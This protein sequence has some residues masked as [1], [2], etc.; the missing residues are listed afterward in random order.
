MIDKM[1]EI[2]TC[3]NPALENGYCESHQA[4]TP[5]NTY[6]NE[7]GK[8]LKLLLEKIDISEIIRFSRGVNGLVAV[9]QS[10]VYMVRGSAIERKVIK[11]YSLNSISSIELR[12]PGLMTN[13]H[14]QIITS[15]N[16]DRTKRFSSAFDYAKDENTIMISVMHGN[17]EEFVA[18][19]QLIYDLRDK[20][21]SEQ[22]SKTSPSEDNFEKIKKLNELYMS[23]IITEEEFKEKKSELLS[24]I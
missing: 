14:F 20:N 8:H 15:G 12:K 13:G 11:S 10:M 24:K 7:G 6:L 23:G 21:H 17:Y 3:T 18:I 9:T 1:C 22:N 16:T 4:F 5:V 2:L 19:E